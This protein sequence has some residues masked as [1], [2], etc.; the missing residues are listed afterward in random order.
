MWINPFVGFGFLITKNT[1]GTKVT[2]DFV[3]CGD[4]VRRVLTGGSRWDI[5]GIRPIEIFGR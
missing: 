1:K 5:V 4:D 3:V 2:K